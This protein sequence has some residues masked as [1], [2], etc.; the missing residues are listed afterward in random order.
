MGRK[1]SFS[2]LKHNTLICEKLIVIHLKQTLKLSI[3]HL[4]TNSDLK[5]Y[6]KNEK[7]NTLLIFYV[8]TQCN[9]KE[10]IFSEFFFEI[11]TP[12]FHE[13]GRNASKY[14]QNPRFVRS[15]FGVGECIIVNSG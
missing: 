3:K 10:K 11:K 2:K 5:V 6:R 7:Q 9:T 4:R 14:S 15:V 13:E 8:L 12:F 1:V